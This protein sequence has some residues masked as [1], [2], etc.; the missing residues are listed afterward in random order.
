MLIL[1]NTSSIYTYIIDM[2]GRLFYFSLP[3]KNKIYISICCLVFTFTFSLTSFSIIKYHIIVLAQSTLYPIR[4][5]LFNHGE[6]SSSS[7]LVIELFNLK[8]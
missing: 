5:H 3:K 8:T 7:Y 1:K 4:P 6:D 2:T